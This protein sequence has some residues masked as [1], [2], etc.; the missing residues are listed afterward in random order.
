[1]L[2]MK[3]FIYIFI[4]LITTS[5]FAQDQTTGVMVNAQVINGDTIPSIE[6]GEVRVYGERIFTSEKDKKQFTRMLRYVK[7]A[8]P[9]AKIAEER[10]LSYA[11]LL[12]TISSDK[13]KRRIM[14]KAE[15]EI[16]EEFINDIKDMTFNEGKM[17]LKLIYRQTQHTSY[18]L[19]QDY[20]GNVRAVFWQ[21]IARIFGANLKSMYDPTG[22]DKYIEEIV[23]MIENGTL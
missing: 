23:Q 7:K 18:E 2:F 5:V 13:E 4:L 15:E 9:Y 22:E 8:Y 1:M 11:K 14:K 20:R 16:K 6:L 19:L 12:S 10:Y 17:L 21:S 3:L